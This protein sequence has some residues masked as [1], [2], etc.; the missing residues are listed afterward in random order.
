MIDFSLLTWSCLGLDPLHTT[1]LLRY[2]CRLDDALSF[3]GLFHIN[4]FY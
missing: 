3:R 4:R 1:P 2:L